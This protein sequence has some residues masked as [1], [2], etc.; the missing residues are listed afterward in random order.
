MEYNIVLFLLFLK[1]SLFIA[2]VLY[3]LISTVLSYSTYRYMLHFLLII[4]EPPEVPV[5]LEMNHLIY[6]SQQQLEGPNTPPALAGQ[7]QRPAGS[8]APQGTS[9]PKRSAGSAALSA[10]SK[11]Q[12]NKASSASVSSGSQEHGQQKAGRK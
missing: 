9:P 4:T 1:L 10:P 7:G 2:N 11:Q 8:R 3:V 5:D 6:Y 12:S